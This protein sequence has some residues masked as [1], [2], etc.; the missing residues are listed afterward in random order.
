[1]C[2]GKP[3]NKQHEG[4][5]YCCNHLRYKKY[6]KITYPKQEEKDIV[7]EK[8]IEKDDIVIQQLE[9]ENITPKKKT[10]TKYKRKDKTIPKKQRLLKGGS[11]RYDYETDPQYQQALQMFRDKIGK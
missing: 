9:I 4:K 3:T 5:Y 1:M 7:E 11:T 8:D 6:G 10:K 2:C